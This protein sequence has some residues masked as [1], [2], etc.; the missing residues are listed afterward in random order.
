ML[1][2]QPRWCLL[3]MTGMGMCW[4][5]PPRHCQ[6]LR[7]SWHRPERYPTPRRTLWRPTDRV[8]RRDPPYEPQP[9]HRLVSG[10]SSAPTRAYRH[11]RKVELLGS[12]KGV[13][14]FNKCTG[15]GICQSVSPDFFEVNDDGKLVVLNDDVTHDELQSV[16]EA[17][18]ECPTDALRIER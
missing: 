12:M 16:E 8:A 9:C 3:S 13:V 17:V 5:E 6:L 18:A 11:L 2:E 1:A 4:G 7:G 10:E 15:L 14:D